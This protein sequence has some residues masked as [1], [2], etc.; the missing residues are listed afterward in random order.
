MPWLHAAPCRNER[1]GCRGRSHNGRGLCL[2]CIRALNRANNLTRP[3]SNDRAYDYQ[4]Q[5]TRA[6]HLKRNPTCVDCGL[7]PT[8]R[9]ITLSRS[10]WRAQ[11]DRENL[12]TRCRSCHARRTNAVSIARD[13]HG[14]WT[15]KKR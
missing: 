6:Q 10:Q 13:E 15:A 4:W 9:S 3:S 1:F 5:K 12:I 2:D 8:S 14:Q 7:T 11:T